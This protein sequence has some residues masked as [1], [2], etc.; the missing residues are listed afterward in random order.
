MTTD[1]LAIE[2]SFATTG[3]FSARFHMKICIVHL[4]Y[5]PVYSMITWGAAI[6]ILYEQAFFLCWETQLHSLRVYLRKQNALVDRY[7]VE[8]LVAWQLKDADHWIFLMQKIVLAV[9]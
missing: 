6:C 3:R 4:R 5:L 2:H 8:G 7:E 1:S 9:L